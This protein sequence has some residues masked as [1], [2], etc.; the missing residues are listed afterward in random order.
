MP[1]GRRHGRK[2]VRRA[3]RHAGFSLMELM[4]GVTILGILLAIALPSF[5]EWVRNNQVRTAAESLREGLQLARSEAVK[6]NARMRLQMVTTVDNSCALS[7]AGPY[8]VVNMGASVTAAGGCGGVVSSTV[9]PFIVQTAPVTAGTARVVVQASGTAVAFDAAGR[10]SAT[11]N[12]TSAVGLFTV[13]VS[14]AA[15]ECLPT[16]DVRCLR[17]LVT[18][19]GQVRMCDRRV[20]A[21]TDPARC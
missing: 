9:S 13:D 1:A 16:G 8:W 21:A 18:P 3:A 19:A 11:T 7:T 12:P 20:T 2:D 5:G 10:Q 6:R 4:V 17:V 15:G 14:S